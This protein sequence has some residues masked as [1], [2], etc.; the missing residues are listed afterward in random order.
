VTTARNLGVLVFLASFLDGVALGNAVLVFAIGQTAGA[1]VFAAVGEPVLL[2]PLSWLESARGRRLANVSVAAGV[3]CGILAGVSSYLM[4]LA[5]NTGL[6]LF[7]ACLVGCLSDVVRSFQVRRSGEWS[8]LIRN[9]LLLATIWFAALLASPRNSAGV[10]FLCLSWALISAVFLRGWRPRNYGS[11]DASWSARRPAISGMIEVGI[12]QAVMQ[13]TLLCVILG[14]GSAHVAGFR[15]AQSVVGPIHMFASAARVVGTVKY[16]Y[17]VRSLG[18]VLIPAAAITF[19]AS[20]YVGVIVYVVPASA[21]SKVFNVSGAT[22]QNLILPL[23][24]QASLAAF[25]AL[26]VA[27]MRVS[28]QFARSIAVRALS[29]VISVGAFSFLLQGE[30]LA[31]AS[32]GLAVG[33]LLV[34][35]VWVANILRINVKDRKIRESGLA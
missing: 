35:P 2:A 34:L 16:S 13:A 14:V 30:S 1:L 28:G 6:A 7:A 29:G 27:T 33:P 8:S 19:M 18:A 10:V 5:W 12:S 32:W 26:A 4:D 22:I 21:V 17:A 31:V 15:M 11:V 20:L 25:A 9:I 3:A 24:I 23:G